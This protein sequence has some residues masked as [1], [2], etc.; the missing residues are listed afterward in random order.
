MTPSPGT[1]ARRS[2][3]I[4]ARR[5]MMS[6]SGSGMRMNR[7]PERNLWRRTGPV[8]RGTKGASEGALTSPRGAFALALAGLEAGVGLVDDED[9]ALAPDDAA[10]LMPFLGRFQRVDDFHGGAPASL[11]A[12]P[13]AA[14]TAPP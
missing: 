8:N 3:A 1:V 2:A 4:W 7:S 12:P 9:A 10:I 11:P 14:P 13:R 5:A 6:P